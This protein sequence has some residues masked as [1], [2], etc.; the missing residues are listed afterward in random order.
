MFL[1]DIYFGCG[2]ILDYV[3]TKQFREFRANPM[4]VDAVIRN[5][6]IIGEASKKIPVSLK[7]KHSGIEWKKIAGLRDILIHEYF[8]IDYD[9]LW[10]IVKHNVP[11]LK[12]QISLILKAD[13]DLFSK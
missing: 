8:G 7:Q 5:L 6:E 1:N 10:D 11:K 3:G 13:K 9:V 2:K 12:S 4:M